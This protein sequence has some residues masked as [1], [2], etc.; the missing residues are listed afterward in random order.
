MIQRIA[1]LFA[2]TG[3][4]HGFSIIALK[5]MARRSEVDQMAGI[6]SVESLIQLMVGLIGFGMQADA[7]RAI[8]LNANWEEKLQQAQTARITLSIILMALSFLAF[9]DN[10][11]LCFLISPLLAS[12]ADYALYAR[13]FSITGAG[14][15]FA[16]VVIP[17]LITIVSVMY[18]PHYV[19]VTYAA[20]TIVTYM[21]TNVFISLFLKIPV[22]HIPSFNSLKLYVK[23]IPLGVITLCLYFFGLGILLLAQLFFSEEELV[24][25]F[26][27]LKFYL[28][29]KG[30]I[31][32]VHQAF[33][34]RM[35][36]EKVCLSIDQISILLGLAILGSILIFPETFITLFF[37]GQFTG[38]RLFF[39]LLGASALVFSIFYSTATRVVLEKKDVAF[40]KIAMASVV[41]SVIVLIIAIQFSRQV[42]V[43]AFSLLAGETFFCC[44][45]ALSFFNGQAVWNRISYLLACSLA[46]VLPLACRIIFGESLS[47]YFISF[48]IMGAGLL[49]FSYKNFTLPVKS[50]NE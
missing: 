34:N 12:S 37:G 46:L 20:A 49:A 7:I 29:Y 35:I 15:A 27:A 22:L 2:I 26:L 24:V 32:V 50:S 39:T 4:G 44:A 31:R 8:S 11:Y 6:A 38:D 19:L 47:T 10:L 18:W 42:E 9:S 30:A 21:M 1:I 33:V 5:F 36:E 17:L 3:A 45:L 41:L 25:S 23:T 13:G 16:R 40:M 14:V 43:I 28:V 48:A